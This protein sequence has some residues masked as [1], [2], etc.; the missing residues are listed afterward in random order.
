MPRP[1][2]FRQTVTSVP[3]VAEYHRDTESSLRLYFTPSHPGFV[4][5]FAGY[6]TSEVND[7][8][9][10]RLAE[11]DIR[12]ALA[13]MTRIEA[14][15]RIDYLERCRQKKADGVSIAFRRLHRKYRDRIPLEE[16]IFDTWRTEEPGTSSLVG[17]LKGA[18]RFRHWLAHGRYFQP[19]LGRK[20][21]FQ[22]VYL[23]AV[24]VQAQFPLIT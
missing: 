8:L 4:A 3:A 5:R 7:E 21:D 16:G 6:A 20:Y 13:V 11:T 15:F 1:A 19:K 18:F 10:D 9:A 2:T 17:E 22:G 14:A 12:S 24:N 23:L